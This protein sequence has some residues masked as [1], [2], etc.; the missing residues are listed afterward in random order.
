MMESVQIARLEGF[1]HVARTGGYA[2]AAR[3]FPY[4]ITQPAVH[5]QV[6]KLEAELGARLFVREA[7]DRMALTAEGRALY[8]FVRPFFEGLPDAVR[9]IR[10][11]TFGGKLT[12]HAAGLLIRKLLPSWLRRL[13]RQRPDVRIDLHEA[14]EP[15][16]PLLRAG[17]TDLV[18][19]F[20][21]SVPPDVAVV[22]VGATFGFA[23]IH[24]N[25]PLASR[26]RWPLSGI[27][28]TFI[29]YPPGSAPHEL[30]ME[31]LRRHGVVPP[32]MLSVGS[33]ESIL[34]FVEAGLGWSLVPWLDPA[35]PSSPHLRARRVES[36][37]GGFPIHLAFRK[38]DADNP[39][40]RAVVEAAT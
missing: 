32:R 21:P 20:L 10:G 25:H 22:K 30:Q 7:R 36:P 12:M 29:G 28:E 18:V 16:L 39:L 31:L 15:A 3:E 13:E 1:F 26:A 14:E 11:K 33:A 38:R 4:P 37:R 24:A 9:A 6:R 34:G 19:D 5:Q 2:R 17:A 23:V 35:G 8:D 40:V 27:R